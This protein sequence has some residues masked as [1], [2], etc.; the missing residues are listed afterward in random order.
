[1]LNTI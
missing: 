1:V